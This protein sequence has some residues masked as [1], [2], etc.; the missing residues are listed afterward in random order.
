MSD[1]NLPPK[2][3]GLPPLPPMPGR[4]GANQP[5]A[6]QQPPTN[7]PQ[8]V[9][10][11]KQ[12]PQPQ[13]WG[14]APQQPSYPPTQH[15]QAPQ[16]Q[17]QQTW[18][19]PQ[20]NGGQTAVYPQT[21]V[22]ANPY[23]PET[24]IPNAPKSKTLMVVLISLGSIVVLGIIGF[25][26]LGF[27]QSTSTPTRESVPVTETENGGTN[28]S[29]DSGDSGTGGGSASSEELNVSEATITLAPNSDYGYGKN[30]YITLEAD[31]AW[32]GSV[33]TEPGDMYQTGTFSTE[34]DGTPATLLPT[35]IPYPAPKETIQGNEATYEKEFVDGFFST[36]KPG[37][38]LSVLEK[39]ITS[40]PA[41]AQTGEQFSGD[42]YFVEKDDVWTGVTFIH[43]YE[44]GASSVITVVSTSEAGVK[45]LVKQ[46]YTEGTPYTLYYDQF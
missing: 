46:T 20:T 31:S 9:S 45:D 3:P 38:D 10:A 32:S 12:A 7:A 30:I 16:G 1:N 14:A 33:T 23:H 25:V 5:P 42:T 13:T 24:Q 8:P 4:L 17:P 39:V 34:Y 35:V 15:P 44:A 29:G 18:Q 26:V 22:T 37:A 2:L 11:P 43:D 19:Q 36:F 6:P 21:G 27:I 41:H 40:I 28:G